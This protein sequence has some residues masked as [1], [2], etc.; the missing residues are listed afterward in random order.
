MAFE[1]LPPAD[2]GLVQHL[3]DLATGARC[4][5]LVRSNSPKE[6]GASGRGI[7]R[8]VPTTSDIQQL[9]R[10]VDEVLRQDPG[11]FVT[12]QLA[13]EP[14]L[15]GHMS[16]ER[17]VSPRR[18]L[19]LI[20]DAD[21]RFQQV[22]IDAPGS[23]Q[24]ASSLAATSED[25]LLPVLRRI[26]GFLQTVGEGFFHCEWVWDRER[27]WLVQAD[28]VQLPPDD[29]MANLYLRGADLWPVKFTPR[30]AGLRHFSTVDAAQ[31]RKL[32]RPKLFVECGFPTADVFLIS[33]D[34][35]KN[36]GGSRNPDLAM[37]LES[38]CKHLVVVRCDVNSDDY[39]FLP[40]SPPSRDP[41]V[42][43]AFME[44]V[45]ADK[46][47]PDS[48]WAFL[49]ANL[50]PAR[51]SAMVQAFPAAERV[52]VDA[53]WGF[54]DGLLHFPYDSYFYYPDGDKVDRTLNHKG[55]C[56][57]FD[58]GAWTYSNVGRPEDWEPTLDSDEVRVL[59]RW[60][61]RLAK[62]L[63]Q[64][65]QL[66]ALARIAGVRGTSGC[67]PWHFTNFDIPPYSE[68]VRKLPMTK[69]IKVL[70]DFADLSRSFASE[71]TVQAYLLRPNANLLRDTSFLIA[72]GNFVAAQ[73]RPLYFEGSLLG[74]SYYVLSNAGAHVVP[75]VSEPTPDSKQY[76][77]LVRDEIPT[78]IRRSGGLARLRTLS[79]QDARIFLARKLLEEAIEVWY[80][81]DPAEV[82][83]ELADVIEVL[84]ALRDQYGI[85]AEDLQSIREKKRQARG[86]FEKLVY[87]EETRPGTLDAARGANSPL[88]LFS[89]AEEWY[90]G[91]SG[92]QPFELR[93]DG[94]GSNVELSRFEISLIPPVRMASGANA[95]TVRTKNHQVTATYEKDKVVLA[96][97]RRQ[98]EFSEN[99][100][101]LFGETYGTA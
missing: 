40:T 45:F 49:L 91:P 63:N 1:H 50:V 21:G 93:V 70:S 24:P 41:T 66:M 89:D 55:L 22:R 85:S 65:V 68:S 20:E 80:A 64:Q 88:P 95:I 86:G 74:H 46:S 77:K 57:L 83:G 54:P 62:E 14:G 3:L 71:S 51:V 87:L 82:S 10:A 73:S 75:I 44:K 79:K 101:S 72:V 35:W 8:S 47:V 48:D 84:D 67:L 42:L 59:S 53:L 60:G 96:V 5:I 16:N 100:L 19:W 12:L 32:R 9:Y 69:E 26:A 78:I 39:M 76:Y 18:S 31:W 2:R 98:P 52:R 11:L 4:R 13:I 92:G 34:D 94:P 17:R 27:V 23:E 99:Q 30:W 97:T 61:L 90:E 58:E 37:D 81:R 29:L 56:L 28:A 38:L 6:S 36:G 7:F 43:L 25:E 15:P 33:G